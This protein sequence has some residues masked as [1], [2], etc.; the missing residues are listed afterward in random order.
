MIHRQT[1]RFQ[2][3]DVFP[4]P[5]SAPRGVVTMNG[6]AKGENESAFRFVTDPGSAMGPE[7]CPLTG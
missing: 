4:V 1:P 7:F 5:Q 2:A 6:A 3:Q